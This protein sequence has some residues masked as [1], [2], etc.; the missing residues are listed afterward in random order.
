MIIIQHKRTYC[1]IYLRYW[2]HTDLSSSKIDHPGVRLDYYWE[3]QGL[4]SLGLTEGIG[5]CGIG[6]S[7]ENGLMRRSAQ[8]VCCKRPWTMWQWESCIVQPW[9]V[10]PSIVAA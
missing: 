3:T 2:M 7:V 4:L 10:Q 8:I 1:T 6:C 5:V 9:I